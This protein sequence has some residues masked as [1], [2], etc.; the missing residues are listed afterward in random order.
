MENNSTQY[1]ISFSKSFHGAVSEDYWS[2][3]GKMPNTLF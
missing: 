1:G 2:I 3:L